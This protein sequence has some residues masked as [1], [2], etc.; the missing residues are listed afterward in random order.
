FLLSERNFA[1]I[2]DL[3]KKAIEISEENTNISDHIVKNDT[4]NQHLNYFISDECPAFLR[5]VDCLAFVQKNICSRFINQ[6]QTKYYLT[7][8]RREFID[9]HHKMTILKDELTAAERHFYAEQSHAA[10]QKLLSLKKIY[11]DTLRFEK[12]IEQMIQ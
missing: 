8:L 12:K 1:I 4:D 5:A 6:N 10:E 3:S 7:D 2:F 11:N 9:M